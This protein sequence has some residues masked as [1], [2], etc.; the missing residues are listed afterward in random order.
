MSTGVV[1]V[2]TFSAKGFDIYGVSVDS[3][4]ANAAFAAKYHFTFPLL[5]DTSKAMTRAFECCRASGDDP[6]AMS[7]RVCVCV[8]AD[9]TVFKYIDPFDALQGPKQ[10]LEEL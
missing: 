10:L 8:D 1:K 7:K 6:C 9:G 2:P 5:C 3:A 4:E